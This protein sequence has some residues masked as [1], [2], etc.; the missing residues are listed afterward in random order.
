MWMLRLCPGSLLSAIARKTDGW[1][2]GCACE[3][4]VRHL[5]DDM[6]DAAR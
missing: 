4:C 5:G 1:A 6:K 2:L 3:G